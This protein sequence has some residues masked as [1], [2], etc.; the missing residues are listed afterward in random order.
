MFA[1]FQQS[2][3][4]RAKVFP[5]ILIK[6]NTY[7]FV[8]VENVLIWNI[9]LDKTGQQVIETLTRRIMNLGRVLMKNYTPN[10]GYLWKIIPLIQGIYEKL[11]P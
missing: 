3:D 8:P 2:W 5:P 9:F 10:P 1:D 4:Y 11:Y 7:L 6:F